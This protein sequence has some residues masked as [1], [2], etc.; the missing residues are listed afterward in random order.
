MPVLVLLFLLVDDDAGVLNFTTD[1]VVSSDFV[2]D[3]ASCT[4]DVE[5]SM[6]LNPTFMKLVAWVRVS[7][8]TYVI[9]TQFPA[10]THGHDC[11]ST[12]MNGAI[13]AGLWI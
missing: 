9:L 1:A 11:Y 10:P 3:P 8:A 2:S 5:A 12:T 6:M 4:F 7:V 13:L